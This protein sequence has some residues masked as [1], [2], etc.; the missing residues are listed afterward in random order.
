M[1]E[2]PLTPQGITSFAPYLEY[3]MDC[4]KHSTELNTGVFFCL[5]CFIYV[6]ATEKP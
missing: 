3:A 5:F 6:T 1:S 2:A 4:R